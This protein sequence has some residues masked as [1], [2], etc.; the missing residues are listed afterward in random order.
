[1]LVLVLLFLF[2]LIVLGD[3]VWE[4]VGLWEGTLVKTRSSSSEGVGLPFM[5]VGRLL[6]LEV[7]VSPSRRVLDYT[8]KAGV[9][10]SRR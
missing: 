10:P 6:R 1:M 3:R 5:E 9:V 2:P 7:K 8:I 4:E